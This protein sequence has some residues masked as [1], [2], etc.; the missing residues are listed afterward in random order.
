[1]RP[2]THTNL[3]SLKIVS[4][5]LVCFGLITASSAFAS[6]AVSKLAIREN[7]SRSHRDELVGKLQKITGWRSLRFESDGRLVIDSLEPQSG[8]KGA[9]QLLAAAVYGPNAIVLED[10]SSRA[11]VAFCRVVPGRWRQSESLSAPAY[12]VLIDFADFGYL[13]GDKEARAAFDVGWGVL[14]ELDHIVTESEDTELDGHVGEC[15]EHINQMREE[16][17][18]PLRV[19]YFFRETNLRADPNFNTRFVRLPFEQRD[20]LSART[21]RYWLTWDSNAVGGLAS[22]TQTASLRL[23]SPSPK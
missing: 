10:A 11:D 18:L 8:S 15:E 17:G 22:N 20:A 14:H 5:T 4:L 16:S 9:R 3:S 2:R 13:V 1:M 21:K 23:S 12:V 19:N 6:K 7:V